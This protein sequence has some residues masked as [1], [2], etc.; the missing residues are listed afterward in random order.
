MMWGYFFNSAGMAIWTIIASL[1]WLALAGVAVWALIQWLGRASHPTSPPPYPPQTP[2][3]PSPMD[4][5]KTRYARGEI[6][7]TTS[8]IPQ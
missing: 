4:T 1:V 2:S 8:H 6:D 7:A 5:L 3:K